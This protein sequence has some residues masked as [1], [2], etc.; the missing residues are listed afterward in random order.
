MWTVAGVSL[1]SEPSLAVYLKESIPKK[2]RSG[3]YVTE[4][5][6]ALIAVTLPRVPSDGK[7]EIANVSVLFSTSLPVSVMATAV[8]STAV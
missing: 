3:V 1:S 8:S 4:A 6:V 7:E 2:F 5:L